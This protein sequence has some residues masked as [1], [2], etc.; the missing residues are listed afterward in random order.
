MFWGLAGARCASVTQLAC[1]GSASPCAWYAYGSHSA[2]TSSQSGSSS[3]TS[4][5]RLTVVP[6]ERS[7][8]TQAALLGSP[9]RHSHTR[10][11]VGVV[12]SELGW[13]VAAESST[14]Q[15]SPRSLG[16]TS[17][18]SVA[19]PTSL[20]PAQPIART[21]GTVVSVV[22]GG[23]R[24][25]I[26]RPPEIGAVVVGVPAA[27]SPSSSHTLPSSFSVTP[28]GASLPSQPAQVRVA[29]NSSTRSAPVP[30]SATTR[31]MPGGSLQPASAT[32]ASAR[33]FTLRAYRERASQSHLRIRDE[34]HDPLTPPSRAAHPH[35][36]REAAADAPPRAAR[37]RGRASLRRAPA[38][39]GLR[40]AS[41]TPIVPTCA[42]SQDGAQLPQA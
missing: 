29:R 4:H 33:Y 2:A 1:P 18:R 7:N 23:C 39:P 25:K 40:A 32:T 11:P 35:S 8:P 14:F 3:G 10:L 24:S 5:S 31:W 28:A 13:A 19:T 41:G 38:G 36:E 34:D 6:S 42:G 12:A 37:A 27:A 15:F 30:A 16:T 9:R 20:S 21:S 26:A 22:P 17:A